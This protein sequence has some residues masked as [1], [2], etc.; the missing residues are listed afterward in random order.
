VELG[1]ANETRKAERLDRARG[2]KRGNANSCALVSGV[3]PESRQS[4]THP[5]VGLG[6]AEQT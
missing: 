6:R 4:E 1:L 5:S 3:L 2:L